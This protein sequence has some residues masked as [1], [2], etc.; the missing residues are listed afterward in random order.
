M[1]AN[2]VRLKTSDRFQVSVMVQCLFS[3]LSLYWITNGHIIHPP[4]EG[5]LPPRGVEITKFQNSVFKVARFQMRATALHPGYFL[6]HSKK[7]FYGEVGEAFARHFCLLLL[8]KKI[9]MDL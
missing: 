9:G 4:V 5:L 2:A 6:W 7:R 8:T 1:A 3:L